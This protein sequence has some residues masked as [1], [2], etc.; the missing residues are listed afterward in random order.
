MY[1]H[2]SFARCRQLAVSASAGSSAGPALVRKLA[3]AALLLCV[4][5]V[6]LGAYVRL[7]DAGLGCPD[8]PGCYGHLTPAAAAADTAVDSVATPGGPFQI[9]KAWREMVHRYAAAT[10][11]LLILSLAVIGVAL[12]RQRVLPLPYVVAL[13]AI[14]V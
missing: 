9:G 4:V 5:V 3:T 13:L 11:G 2:D 12:R 1:L 10:L 8:W 14:V 7:T 6:V